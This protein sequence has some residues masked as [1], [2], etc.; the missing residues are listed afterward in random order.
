MANAFGSDKVSMKYFAPFG[1]N[2]RGGAVRFML[3]DNGIP[4][5][6]EPIIFGE[7][8]EK[9]KAEWTASGVAPEGRVPV[10]TVGDQHYNQS[11]AILAYLGDKTG[12]AGKDVEERYRLNAVHDVLKDLQDQM[13]EK[14]LLPYVMGGVKDAFDKFYADEGKMFYTALEMYYKRWSGAGPY[15]CGAR[16]TYVDFLLFSILWDIRAPMD[17][18]FKA[19]FPKLAACMAAVE[20]RPNMVKYLAGDGKEFAE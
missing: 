3:A 5:T 20:A 16:A 10:L 7:W 12:M 6:Y 1:R 17:D 2:S 8:F 11:H 9:T 18:A 15:L 4:F 14:A 13:V 19:A